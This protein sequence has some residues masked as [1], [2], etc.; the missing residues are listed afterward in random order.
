MQKNKDSKTEENSQNSDIDRSLFFGDSTSLEQTLEASLRSSSLLELSNT[1]SVDSHFIR[2]LKSIYTKTRFSIDID[3]CVL[4][5]YVN[6]LWWEAMPIIEN[7]KFIDLC[8]WTKISKNQITAIESLFEI[9]EYVSNNHIELDE[10]DSEMSNLLFENNVHFERFKIQH[11]GVAF[12]PSGND[13][14]SQ[15]DS[16]FLGYIA[17]IIS[18]CV[19]KNISSHYLEGVYDSLQSI[20]YKH[21][22]ENKIPAMYTDPSTGLHSKLGF[23]KLIQHL[24]DTKQKKYF[25]IVLSLEK[26]GGA[27][28]LLDD[29]VQ[30]TLLKKSIL[31]LKSILP[32]NK[33][34]S[35]L[36]SN[37]LAFIMI[38]STQE[39]VD[40]ILTKIMN[41]FLKYLIVG[42]HPIH[43]DLI[44]GYSCDSSSDTQPNELLKMAYIALYQAKNTPLRKFIGYQD[45]IVQE[46]QLHLKLA[47][48]LPQAIENQEFILHFQ[49]I[50]YLHQL[51][52]PAHH[53]EALIRWKHPKKGFVPPDQFI[54]IAEKSGDIVHIG[55]WAIREVCR[56][57][58]MPSVPS[59]V[60][61]SINLSPV[62]L[63]ESELVQN[64]VNILNEY[65]I[66]PDRITIEITENSAMQDNELTKEKF[67]E[68]HQA[69][70]KLSMDD[71][72]TGYSSLSYLLNFHF[73]IIKIDKSFIDSTLMDKQYQLIAKTVVQLAHNLSLSVVCEG[74]ETDKQYQMVCDWN[75]DMIQGYLISKP[76]PWD[77]FYKE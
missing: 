6:G 75:T 15:Y 1:I 23:L 2:D 42:E 60:G 17:A 34:L 32:N 20:A 3:S 52:E 61:V 62:Q 49:P 33:A 48:D 14:F 76:M 51:N 37:E 16:A 11:G 46:L 36:N 72:G 25:V 4:F 70:L 63:K 59:N 57:L 69:G 10:S 43:C 9:R 19:D 7:H 35:K 47:D 12:K 26:S 38:D 22:D 53:Y 28:N 30:Q 58:S 45:A 21:A 31:R 67:L 13:S 54:G 27:F 71:F 5:R 29:E 77:A 66:S 24:V 64:I 65:S 41:A 50:S 44:A 39:Q 68:F 55:Y 18:F 74:I 8:E 56:S 40:H 73:D